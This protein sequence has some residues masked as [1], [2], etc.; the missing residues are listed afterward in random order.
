MSSKIKLIS[1]KDM[2]S[3][4]TGTL[5]SFL[6]NTKCFASK[7]LRHGVIK[8]QNFYFDFSMLQKIQTLIKYF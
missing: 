1:A 8:E 4:L 7:I 3:L 2:F 5:S 6:F